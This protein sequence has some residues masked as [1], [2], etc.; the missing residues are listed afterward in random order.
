[1]EGDMVPIARGLHRRLRAPGRPFLVVDPRRRR[2][3]LAP[4]ARSPTARRM[5]VDAIRDARH[6]T[7]AIRLGLGR[8]PADL[9]Q[10]LPLLRSAD[11]VM[12][13]LCASP[14]AASDTLLIRPA[15][16]VVAPLASR[17]HELDRIIAEYARDA[18]AELA[19]PHDS[20]TGED[21]G[22]VRQRAAATYDEIE[23]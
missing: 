18:I 10:V 23:K 19:A 1:G 20:F 22:W 9:D 12:L 14:R 15:P 7:L 3:Q 8:E 16:V 11:D 13:V 17:A 21:L 2:D 6:G 4:S 5:A